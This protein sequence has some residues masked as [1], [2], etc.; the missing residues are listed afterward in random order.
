MLREGPWRQGKNMEGPVRKVNL[1]DHPE[2]EPVLFGE[3]LVS[4]LQGASFLQAN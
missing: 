4:A 3:L 2:D 1:N